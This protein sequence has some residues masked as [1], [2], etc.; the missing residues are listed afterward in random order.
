[1]G[2]V[3]EEERREEEVTAAKLHS[4]LSA[5]IPTEVGGSVPL[6]PLHSGVRCLPRRFMCLVWSK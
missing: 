2:D 1:M 5:G 4:R 3:E 6:F